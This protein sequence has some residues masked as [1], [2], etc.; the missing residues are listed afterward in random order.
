MKNHQSY[1]EN[2]MLHR[3]EARWPIKANVSPLKR[4][5][6]KVENF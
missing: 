1:E 6:Q 5:M 2:Q 3:V 4:F